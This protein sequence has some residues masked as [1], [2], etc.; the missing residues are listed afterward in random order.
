VVLSTFGA[1]FTPDHQA[2]AFEMSR[3]VREGGRLGFANWS[4]NGFIGELFRI[5]G[6]YVPPPAGL[7][8]PS[9]WGTEAHVSELFSNHFVRA[10]TRNFVFR[11][12]SPEHWLE[13][14]RNF[15][16]PINRAFNALDGDNQA[17][18][19]ADIMALLRRANRG[20]D[21]TLTIPSEYLEV[22]VTKQ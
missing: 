18:L 3:V 16:G 17:K 9:L 19:E 14:F 4:P 15:Y 13:T 22:V 2:T 7:Q 12:T 1:M 8:P 11:Y 20:G 21:G 10:S 6:R 5:V